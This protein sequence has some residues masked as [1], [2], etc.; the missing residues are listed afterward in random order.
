MPWLLPPWPFS[1]ILAP[2]SQAARQTIVTYR[3]SAAREGGSLF[4]HR[5]YLDI[6]L[7]LLGALGYWQLSRSG[8]IIS[9]SAT[10]GL[11]FDPLLL[12]TPIVLVAGLTF[13]ALRFVPFVV[14]GLARLRTRPAML[15]PRC[16][17]CARWRAPLPA[18]MA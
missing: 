13:V 12:L 8:T 14:R 9:R 5:F 11:E 7:V 15:S 2:T 17:A 3:R 4:V 16:L 10:G 18:T 1:P 6:V